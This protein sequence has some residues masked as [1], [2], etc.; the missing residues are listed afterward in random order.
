MESSEDISARVS[1]WVEN[2]I[3]SI[4]ITPYGCSGLVG[5]S[6]GFIEAD[7]SLNDFIKNS[8]KVILKAFEDSA[9]NGDIDDS[10]NPYQIVENIFPALRSDKDT[11]GILNKF[12]DSLS[13]IFYSKYDK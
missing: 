13:D 11:G 4:L 9:K 8:T 7:Y 12:V 6:K 2:T 5:N 10:F 3:L 1:K